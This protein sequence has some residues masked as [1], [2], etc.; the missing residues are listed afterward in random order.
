MI[1]TI[2]IINKFFSCE[3]NL[4][5]TYAFHFTLL[6][7]Y[8]VGRY[9]A[10][11]ML[12]SSRD[13]C[14]V[15]I[16][17][18]NPCIQQ[19]GSLWGLASCSAS[20]ILTPHPTHN[21]KWSIHAHVTMRKTFPFIS[22]PAHNLNNRLHTHALS[23]FPKSITLLIYFLTTTNLQ[24]PKKSP[25]PSIRAASLFLVHYIT[26]LWRLFKA[27]KAYTTLYLSFYY[28]LYEI[29]SYKLIGKLG[30]DVS[31]FPLLIYTICD[32]SAIQQTA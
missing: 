6:L 23:G 24:S 22:T 12:L 4:N 17:I 8:A 20:T 31:K 13:L 15:W 18:S 30:Y 9:P 7:E 16:N 5:H 26:S 19:T 32:R 11:W 2:Q 3:K 25:K 21:R 14:D 28:I 10:C 1:L 29:H 27:N